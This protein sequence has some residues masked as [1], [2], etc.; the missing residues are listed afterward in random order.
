MAVI[1]AAEARLLIPSLKGATEDTNL[2][3]FIGRADAILADSVG[4]PAASAVGSATFDSATY[5]RYYEGEPDGKTVELGFIPITS[6]TSV[7]DDPDRVYGSSTLVSSG[8]YDL[9]GDTGIIRL[10]TTGTHGSFSQ[11][12]RSIKVVF[13]AGY[14]ATTAPEHIK[15]AVAMMARHLWRLRKEQGSASLGKKGELRD[16]TIPAAINQMLS[17]AIGIASVAFG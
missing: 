14:T 5:T 1:T 9:E 4:I 2:D 15:Q 7:H 3:T 16:E 10:T 8:D 17:P 6:I 13:V 12:V 11:Q